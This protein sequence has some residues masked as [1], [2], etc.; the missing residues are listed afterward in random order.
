MESVD[1]KLNDQEFR[2][3]RTIVYETTGIS[4]AESKRALVV[5]RLYKRL[6][7]L[8]FN[9]F[10]QYIARLESD[11]DE[12]SFFI[13]RIT[14]NLTKFYREKNQFDVFQHRILPIIKENKKRKG[15]KKLRIW[16]AG[17]STGEEVYTILFELFKAYQGHPPLS[18][19]VKI[20]GSDIDTE[21]LKKAHSAQYTTE[22][23]KGLDPI[24]LDTYFDQLSDTDYR[25]QDWLRKFVVFKRI[26]LVYD[27]FHFK[28]K[29]DI[30][31][32]RN[33]LIY[34]NKETRKRVYEKFHTVLNNPGF[35]FSGHSENL[36]KFNH[37][38]EFIEK[39]IYKKVG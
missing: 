11:M 19:D 9:T 2:K 14:T 38:F 4:L 29:I 1:L 13:N 21:V 6:R 15:E 37:L 20:L 25:M 18:V 26:N 3:I 27:E 30:I 24:A 8:N 28:N 16:S 7:E 35:F 10:E 39:S 12:I 36:F 23:L 22:E 32:C 5:S 31:F 34:F 17:C 33:V